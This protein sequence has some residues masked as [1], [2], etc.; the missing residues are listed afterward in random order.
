MR[1]R[2]FRGPWHPGPTSGISSRS[3]SSDRD[4]ELPRMSRTTTFNVYIYIYIYIYTS[5]S[6]CSSTA[7]T[8][9]PPLHYARFSS[10]RRRRSP[11]HLQC[12]QRV[13][14]LSFQGNLLFPCPPRILAS[15]W[16]AVNPLDGHLARYTR[17][18][19]YLHLPATGRVSPYLPRP[20]SMVQRSF[21]R[22][23]GRAGSGCLAV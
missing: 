9:P 22:P 14:P 15:L 6:S 5:D 17:H 19:F 3:A 23:R 12:R 4:H 8:V 21:P 20:D 11:A 7:L 2:R 18:S 10:H 13:L 16:P 1:G